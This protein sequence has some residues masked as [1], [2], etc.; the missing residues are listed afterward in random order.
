LAASKFV[1]AIS[2]GMEMIVEAPHRCPRAVTAPVDFF[3]NGFR[4][5]SFIAN[6]RQ[7]SRCWQS[8][9]LAAGPGIGNN[10]VE[11]VRAADGVMI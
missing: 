8:L 2:R 11:L 9:T 6:F 4:L 3:F 10:A 1:D 7:Q 5:P